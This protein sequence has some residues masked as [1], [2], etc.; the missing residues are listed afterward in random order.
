MNYVLQVLLYKNYFKCNI[1]IQNDCV[2]KYFSDNH[3]RVL[4]IEKL[5][6]KELVIKVKGLEVHKIINIQ[7]SNGIV[8]DRNNIV[9]H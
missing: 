4:N 3:F 5:N 2:I 8:F 7:S 6:S 9:K 1:I